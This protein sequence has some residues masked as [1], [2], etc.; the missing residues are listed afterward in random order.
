MGRERVPG[1]PIELGGDR[2]G[3]E[4]QDGESQLHYSRFA[5]YRDMG[6]E[7]T[8]KQLHENLKATGAT[9]TLAW[10]YQISSLYRWDDRIR[11]WDAEQDR[12]LLALTAKKR[13]DMAERHARLA[14]AMM[15]KATQALSAVDPKAMTA[16]EL[17]KMV[18]AA[19]RIERIALGQPEATIGVSAPDGGPV[20]VVDYTSLSAEQRRERLAELA[21][22]AARRAGVAPDSQ[23]DGE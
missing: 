12:L 7:R 8:L 16:T 5:L 9:I 14:M 17:V 11:A 6:P 18:E 20:G 15:G 23:D 19:A 2:P 4:R 22:E 3:W 10:L 21:R 13:R 1:G